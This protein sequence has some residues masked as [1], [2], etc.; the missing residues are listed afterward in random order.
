MGIKVTS[1]LYVGEILFWTHCSTLYI[2][3]DKKNE[4]PTSSVNSKSMVCNGCDSRNDDVQ[5]TFLV[6]RKWSE[7]N[8]LIFQL[9]KRIEFSILI[10]SYFINV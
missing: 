4:A 8:I 5:H 1:Y 3:D 6:Q 10:P 9:Y 2:D 7:I